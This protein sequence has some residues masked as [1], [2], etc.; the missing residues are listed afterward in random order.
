MKFV[1]Y[2]ANLG[3]GSRREVER[4]FKHSEVTDR[5]GNALDEDD[6]FSHDKVLVDGEPLD[7]PPGSALIFNKPVG[8]VCS[9]KEASSLIY[10]LLPP[11]FR[12]RTPIMAP[13]GR[14]DRDTSGL[15]LLTD[16]GQ[17]NHR[18]TSPKM[19]LP[20]VYR[21]ELA[22]DLRGDEADLFASGTVM[23]ENETDVLKPAD[24]RVLSARGVE[25]TLTEG[26]YHQV[27]RMFAAVGN[28]VEAL[29]RI[30]IGSVSLGELAPGAWRVLN[31]NEVA[32]ISSRPI[33]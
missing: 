29:H 6:T 5:D 31:Q 10:E 16:D 9:T 28:H 13:I 33:L 7:P 32:L 15:L 19:H 3:Y 8:Y 23:L 17:L 12:S 11:R 25:L 21:A 14:L 1:K 18:V 2:L 30:S 26:R 4:M 20:K 22:A 27:R 24:L